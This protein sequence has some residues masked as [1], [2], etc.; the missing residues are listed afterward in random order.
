MD[1]H[2]RHPGAEHLLVAECPIVGGRLAELAGRADDASEAVLSGSRTTFV[3]PVPSRA[4]RVAIERRR[5]Q[6]IS[7]PTHARESFDAPPNVVEALWESVMRESGREGVV[8]APPQG[9]IPYDP[10]AYRTIYLHWL[11]H[12]RVEVLEIDEEVASPHSVYEVAGVESELRATPDEVRMIQE[13][14][15]TLA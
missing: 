2:Q 13:R 6:T 14:L 4:V 3:L 11:R 8:P 9:P 1:W 10:D 7:A 5:A 12:R 15:Y